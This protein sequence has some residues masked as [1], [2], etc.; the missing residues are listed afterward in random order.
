MCAAPDAA[1]A[2]A[3]PLRRG[4]RRLGARRRASSPR[5]VSD[6]PPASEPS[7]RPLGLAGQKDL[8]GAPRRQEKAL[9]PTGLYDTS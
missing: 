9:K 3:P 5:A 4:R 6:Q 7:T 2:C 8:R 1:A